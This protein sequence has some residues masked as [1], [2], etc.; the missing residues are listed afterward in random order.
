MTTQTLDSCEVRFFS[1]NS[2]P[3]LAVD[4]AHYLCVPLDPTFITRF[5]NED[6]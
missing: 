2:N 4:I 1:G 5:S 6:L 3:Q